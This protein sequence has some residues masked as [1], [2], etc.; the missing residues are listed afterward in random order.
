[1]SRLTVRPEAELDALEAASWYDAERAGLE[2]EFLAELRATFSRVEDGPQRCPV[3]PPS[4]DAPGRR[5]FVGPSA[6]PTFAMGWH[7]NGSSSQASEPRNPN[8]SLDR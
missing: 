1:M 2:T 4:L 5:S 6:S 8:R 3:G 7:A